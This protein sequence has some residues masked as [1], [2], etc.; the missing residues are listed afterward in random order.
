M[1]WLQ[2]KDKQVEANGLGVNVIT[3]ILNTDV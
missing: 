2:Y 3:L 1:V